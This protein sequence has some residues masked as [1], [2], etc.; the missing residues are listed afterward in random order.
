LKSST[1][2]NFITKHPRIWEIFKFLVVGGIATLIDMLVMATVIFFINKEVFA[3]NFFNVVLQSGSKKNQILEY[4]SVL[5][6][7]TGFVCGLV[8]NYIMSVK[9]V[10]LN[11][12]YAKTFNGAMLFT[13]LSVVG[14]LIHLFGMWVFF[15]LLK[16]N[17]WAVKIVITAFVLV[18]NYVTRKIFIFRADLKISKTIIPKPIKTFIPKDKE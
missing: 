3:Y 4:S 9:F 6:T 14:F 2:S 17:Y 18:F 7:S 13:V 16:I 10:F 12:E 15:E 11:K 8:F 1:L 5:G